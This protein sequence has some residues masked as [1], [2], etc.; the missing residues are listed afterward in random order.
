MKNISLAV[1][2]LV[3]A[4]QLVTKRSLAH[5]RL[6]SYVLVGVLLASA[7]LSGTVIYF[8]ALRELALKNTLAKHT[9]SELD[10]VVKVRQVTT[11]N[12]EYAKAAA[13]VN[14]EIDTRVGWM[15]RDR[16]RAG[17]SATF[18]LTTPGNEDE[19]GKD[20]ARTYFAFLPRLQE[21]TVALYDGRPPRAQRLNPQDQPP[22]LEA[23]VSLEAAR[24]FDVG[25]GDRLVAV[26]SWNDAVPY[27]T[28]VISGI[29]QRNA[30]DD[31]ELWYLEQN[32]L[33][34]ATGATF[35]TIPFY[36]S[37]NAYMEVLGPSLLKM[38]S[39]YVWL[40]K[41]DV[42]RVNAR[43]TAPTVANMD[44][45]NRTLGSALPNYSQTSALDNALREYDQ[46]LFFSK[47]PMF[48]VL[49][50]IAVVILYYVGTMSSLV[51][52]NQRGEV[53]VLRSRGADS[54]QTIAVFVLEGATIAIIAILTAPLLAAVAISILGYTPA[55]SDLTGGARL[56]VA[57]SGG[58][59]MMSALGGALSFFALIIPAV[60]ASR[61]GV[62]QQRQQSA[63]P[64]RLPAFQRYYA[65]VLL[66]LISIFLF[67]QLTEQGS[68]VAT[69]HL[70]E[71]TVDQ[72]L[73]AVPGLTL[74]ASAMVLL[75]LFPLAMSLVSRLLSGWLPAGPVMSV[76]QMA[77]DPT[78]YAR[79]SLLL[80]LTA[81]LGIFAASFEAT[82]DRSTKERILYST[83]SDIRVESVQPVF[84]TSPSATPDSSQVA[85][86]EPSVAEAYQQVPGVER[87]SAVLRV[88]GRDLTRPSGG[89]FVMLAVE[90]ESFGDIA[91]F[92][93]D[94]ADK[95]MDSLLKSVEV[96]DLPQALGLELPLDASAVGV[97]IRADRLQPTVKVT[98]RL[99]NAQDQ[100]ANYPLGT[101][102]T[103]E[104]MVLETGLDTGT[105]LSFLQGLP[106]TLVSLHVEETGIGRSL[107]PGSVLLDDVRVTT[108]TGETRFIEQFDDAAG[109]S[110]LRT[111][112]E[113]IPDRLRAS[114][115][116]FDG[117]SGSVLFSWAVGSPMTPRGI[118]YG[119]EPSPLP[120]LASKAFV[121]DTGH[122]RGEEF[123]I[124]VA[125]ARILVR[126]VD[127]VDLFPTMTALAQSYLV[128]DL[129]ALNRYAEIGG[130]DRD[131]GLVELWISATANAPQREGLAERLENIEGYK[132]TS[133]LDRAERMADVDAKVDPLVKAGWRA[134]LFIAFTAV[135]I[136]SCLG[137]LVHA[138]VSFR[139]R[140]LHFALLR[141]VGFST[142][143]LVTM[144]WLEQTLV[145]AVGMAL[146]TWMGGRLGATIMPFLGHDDWGGQVIPPFAMQ[147]NWAPLL[148]TYAAILFVFAVI[149]LG[150]IW[151]IQRISLQRI[152]RLGEV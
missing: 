16:I 145:I 124:S 90:G 119:P 41:T 130:A 85:A 138:Y 44:V 53:A 111:T 22:E 92:R 34:V 148:T 65:D 117:E 120:V 142:R 106:L 75:R 89:S 121:E 81:G 84:D 107:Q 83:G 98:A 112:P 11:S 132:S 6:V 20:N 28:V 103:T 15:L 126:L 69:N 30:I 58:A 104:W 56:T 88:P 76:W 26:P 146:G 18:F 78:H 72:L 19:A 71:S 116:I 94:F 52:E 122:P 99:R 40:L 82:L 140:Q 67:R 96:A 8:D 136:L 5:W 64:A 12:E 152:L 91:W 38:E 105:L 35:R 131:L 14:G 147:V 137:F 86:R 13:F 33:Q 61:V 63:R 80:I 127:I 70:G 87:A 108:K 45:M 32:V 47:L 74:V 23:I 7:M 128:A 1:N 101:L 27:V 134:L 118:F 50:V 39:T 62:V 9:T 95:P 2:R 77:R 97:R 21:P 73:L 51:I 66:L 31:D 59:Y 54:A 42:G 3:S 60:Q 115:E 4:W 79:L 57:I 135:L 109:W 36:V 113:A 29:F 149:S 141:T 143:Q 37:E 129:A 123:E 68:V 150:L 55:F 10:I 125:R 17:K 110:V 25:V 114:D 151:L 48:V 46:R 144:V 43:N 49:I 24:L 133:I 139:N 100:Y 93:E 102:D